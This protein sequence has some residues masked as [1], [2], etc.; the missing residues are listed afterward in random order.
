MPNN[1]QAV[2][3]DMDG[4]IVD[5]ERLW[6][7]K[8]LTF[9]KQLAGKWTESDQ[10]EIT[11]R[12]LTDIYHILTNQYGV[13]L[14]KHEFFKEYNKIAQKLY[15]KEVELIAGIIDLLHQVKTYSVSIALV[16]SSPHSWI[17]IVISR[18]KLNHFFD[19][20]VSSDDIKGKGKPAPDIYL[21]ASN[22]LRV[23]PGK[24]LVIEDS[25]NGV[26]AAKSAGMKCI[27]L[28][29]S[30]ETSQ[31]KIKVDKTVKSHQEII[32]YLLD[33]SE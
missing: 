31:K 11:G 23:K 5:S 2:I 3:F 9:L 14:S 16:S 22:K 18:F 17:N 10:K 32:D 28:K 4:V 30:G 19:V 33:Q 27:W 24:C 21:F 25:L 1:F 12:S 29:Q 20:I 6:A 7:K 13:S 26:K 8:E 15:R